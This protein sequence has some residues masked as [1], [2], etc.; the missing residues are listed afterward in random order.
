MT[1]RVLIVDDEPTPRERLR[2]LLD[3]ESDVEVVGDAEDG[4]DA[5]EAIAELRPDVVFLDIQ[6]PELSGLEVARQIDEAR[7]PLIIFV[8][9]YDQYAIEAFEVHAFDYLLKPFDAARLQAPLRRARQRLASGER[10]D[11]A[12]MQALLRQIEATQR[13]LSEM[14]AAPGKTFLERV[15]VRFDGRAVSVKVAEVERFE[16]QGNYV[17]L[18]TPRGEFEVRETLSKFEAKLDPK[19]FQRIHRKTI[20]NLDAVK[21]VQTWFSGDHIMILRSGA[22]VRHSRY[23]RQALRA[24]GAAEGD[25]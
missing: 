1:M 13:E 8:T 17:R 25:E 5:I 6:M 10:T 9:A 22:K 18:Y 16:A 23:Y 19:H 2:R 24:L 14:V 12:S 4:R 15:L 20:V 3:A 7:G 21:E 11:M